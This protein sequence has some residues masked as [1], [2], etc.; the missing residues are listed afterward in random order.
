MVCQGSTSSNQS[1][2]FFYSGDNNVNPFYYVDNS[3]LSNTAGCKPATDYCFINN[4]FIISPARTIEISLAGQNKKF[5]QLVSDAIRRYKEINHVSSIDTSNAV[6]F[7]FFLKPFVEKFCID[8]SIVFTRFGV[9]AEFDYCKKHYVLD[10]DYEEPDSV[11]IL[12][13]V[14]GDICTKE[15]SLNE[16]ES[17]FGSF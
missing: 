10:Y 4:N 13:D 6:L 17:V 9:K 7:L 2:S 14:D 16:L 8:P 15:C 3:Q 5:D 12:C 11:I 1:L